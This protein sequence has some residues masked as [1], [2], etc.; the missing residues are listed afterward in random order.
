[1]GGVGFV[2]LRMKNFDGI[3]H[4]MEMALNWLNQ[5]T[6]QMTKENL[7][8]M[9]KEYDL[10]ILEVFIENLFQLLIQHH[11]AVEYITELEGED[12]TAIK[13][14]LQRAKDKQQLHKL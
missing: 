1:M 2:Q 13:D 5:E 11:G 8:K 4:A 6:C 14:F 9:V 7:F 10:D 12:Q 3:W